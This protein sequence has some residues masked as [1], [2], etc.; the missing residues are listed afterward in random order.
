M[1]EG[2]I[3]ATVES[4]KA[5]FE[6]EA[7]DTGTLIR[8]LFQV[9][10]EAEVLQPIAYIGEPGEQVPDIDIPEPAARVA[11]PAE[12]DDGPAPTESTGKNKIFA[13]PAVRRL[14]REHNIPLEQITGSGPEGRIIKR[15]LLPYLESG[16]DGARELPEEPGDQVIPF[17][18]LRR[19]IARRLSQSK[20][21]IP[22]Y[23]LSRHIDVTSMLAKRSNYNEHHPD[24]ASINDVIVWT[25]AGALREFPKLN[26]HVIGHQ[27]ILR[28]HVNIGIAVVVEDG[29]LVPVIPDADRKDLAEISRYSKE[30]IQKAREGVLQ[31]GPPG[32]FTVSNL[33]NYGISEFQA[34]INP[35]ET[36]IL[37]VGNAEKR[38]V[39]GKEGV[40]FAD[41]M[42][43]GLACDH[44][45][46]DG[47]YGARF[48]QW[49]AEKLENLNL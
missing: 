39:P 36:A 8:I 20:H 14:A 41:H 2:D 4:E 29:L 10:Q 43:F 5:A 32:T 1:E 23:Y 45:V 3:L 46:I 12:A 19:G 35:P 22:H 31:G 47:A 17:S 40:Q 26:A 13:S 6:V 7:V 30:I 15:D 18:P 25:V 9:G 44:R 16:K 28:G 49:L 48:L 24:K 21:E 11:L 34:I 27:I 37:T 38:A 33:G 42:T